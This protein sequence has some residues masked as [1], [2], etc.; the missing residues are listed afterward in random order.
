MVQITKTPIIEQVSKE[1]LI[2]LLKLKYSYKKIGKI[3]G[4]STGMVQYAC[5]FVYGIDPV[6]TKHYLVHENLDELIAEYNKG[7]SL[8]NLADIYKSNDAYI[9]K[10]LTEIGVH[11]RNISE[12]LQVS[13]ALRGENHYAWNPE[14]TEDERLQNRGLE[15]KQWAFSVKEQYGFKC[16]CCGKDSN[17]DMVSHHLHN[18]KDFPDSRYDID[19]GVCLCVKCHIAFHVKYGKSFNTVAQYIE[20]KGAKNGN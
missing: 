6:K 14:L 10:I 7:T 4:M 16:D 1:T 12:S 17:G 13:D 9:K 20:F 2:D 18:Y 3:V 8:Y 11:T 15:Y 5:L 19:N